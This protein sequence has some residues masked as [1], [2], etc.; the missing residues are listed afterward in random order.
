[1]CVD[2]WKLLDQLILL[3]WTCKL[4]YKSSGGSSIANKLDILFYSGFLCKLVTEKNIL[5]P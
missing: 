3:F 5:I 1:M 4:G 2:V